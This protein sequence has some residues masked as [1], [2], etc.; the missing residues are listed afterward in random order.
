[1]QPSGASRLTCERPKR[2]QPPRGTRGRSSWSGRSFNLLRLGTTWRHDGM[3]ARRST[4]T[5][6]NFGQIPIAQPRQQGEMV[7][8]PDTYE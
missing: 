4:P 5:A 7:A 8:I 3:A 1:M 6:A 2:L